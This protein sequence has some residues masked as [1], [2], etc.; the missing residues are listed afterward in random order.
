MF[1]SVSSY[2][3]LIQ[4]NIAF[5]EG[6]IKFSPYHRGP[7]DPETIPLLGDLIEINRK[8]FISTC[9]QPFIESEIGFNE[10]RNIWWETQ[11][12]SFIDGY[13][14][15]KYISNFVEFM[16]TR[17]N[18][19]Y[20]VYD[21]KKIFSKWIWFTLLY[22][23]K[24]YVTVTSERCSKNREQLEHEEWESYST[25]PTDSPDFDF[26]GYPNIIDILIPYT[27][28]VIIISHNS[29]SVEKLLLEFFTSL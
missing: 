6:K 1:S 15:K 21:M 3:E 22:G 11:Q 12:L 2:E 23:F 26:Y 7:I 17:T 19:I 18:F 28:R 14:P 9:G 13:L 4:T 24:H 20:R 27:T 10:K 8:G 25:I 16:K 29:E 5:I